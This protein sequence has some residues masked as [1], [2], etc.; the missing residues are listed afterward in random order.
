MTSCIDIDDPRLGAGDLEPRRR[1][2]RDALEP[3]ANSAMEV[4][5][6]LGPTTSG[7]RR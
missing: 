5:R 2:T 7:G 3:V 6:R 1:F 4:A